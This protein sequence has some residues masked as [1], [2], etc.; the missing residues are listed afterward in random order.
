MLALW[1]EIPSLLQP[2]SVS[3]RT[4]RAAEFAQRAISV[5]LDAPAPGVEHAAGTDAQPAL[6]LAREVRRRGMQMNTALKVMQHVFQARSNALQRIQ[7]LRRL[8]PAKLNTKVEAIQA[9][10]A[11]A[12]R[13]VSAREVALQSEIQG[14]EGE[15]A[16]SERQRLADW[17]GMLDWRMRLESMPSGFWSC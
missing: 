7:D 12:A 17:C 3:S 1:Q 4:A 16:R 15:R 9:P 2:A 10:F 6:S 14:D 5:G 11:S 8:S 13:L